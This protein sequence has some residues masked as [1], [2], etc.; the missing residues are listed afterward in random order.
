MRAKAAD[1][2]KITA[3]DL[4]ELGVIDEIVPEPPGGAHADHDGHGEDPARRPGPQP[5]GAAQGLKPEK[6]VRK[7]REKFLGM[8]VFDE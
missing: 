8:G 1:A 7:R 5:R 2:L 6:L 4:N 3:S